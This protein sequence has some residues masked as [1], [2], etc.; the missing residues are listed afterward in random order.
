MKPQVDL[1]LVKDALK[2]LEIDHLSL[3][4]FDQCLP[5]F[6]DEDIGWGSPYSNGGLDFIEFAHSI[7]FNTIQFGPKGKISK[8]DISP[9]N[10]T[11][12]SNNPLTI[13]SSLL[14]R[15]FPQLFTPDEVT[16]L[17]ERSCSF[18]H[19]VNIPTAW[20]SMEYL[21]D[22]VYN[23]LFNNKNLS[24]LIYELDVFKSR[25]SDTV[26]NWFKRDSIFETLSFHYKTD[27]WKKWSELDQNLFYYQTQHHQSEIDSRIT[28]LTSEYNIIIQKYALSQFLLQL[29]HKYLRKYAAKTGLKIYGDMQIGFSNQDIWAW[30][31]L[32]LNGY[33]MG[34][35]PSRS[36]PQGQPWGYPVL[37]PSLFFTAN[38]QIGPA[39]ELI[40][41]RIDKMLS[42][43]DG[44]RIDHPHGLISPW[45]YN[46]D[47][48]DLFSAV[49]KGARLYSSPDL[50][51]HPMLAKFT[52]VDKNQLNKDPSCPRY[53]DNWVTA[54]NSDQ[55]DKY[56][57]II[58][59]ILTRAKNAGASES[60]IL[61]E[62]LSTWPLPLKEVMKSRGLGR[63]CVTQKTDPDNPADIYRRE[64]SS[65]RDWIMVG[66][67]DTKPIWRLAAEKHATPW[68][69]S[70]AEL[71]ANQF[72]H[73][74]QQKNILFNQIMNSP[75]RFC[76]AMFSELFLG[77]ARNVFIFFTDLLGIK[78]VYNKP[79]IIDDE[80]WTIR[81]P[82]DYHDRYKIQSKNGEAVNIPKCLAMAL[83][84]RFN[85][86]ED[87]IR[88]AERLCQ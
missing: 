57:T 81:I 32:F 63:F 55:T 82:A 24:E 21:L 29:Q 35:P 31:S 53:A 12:F 49:Q 59:L 71:L 9:Y 68:Y 83:T 61:C 46:L 34:A 20:N 30:R 1:S 70:R 77:P 33:L 54:L 84:A 37:D 2:M 51:D 15:Q 43:F 17:A 23:R 74:E 78:E 50:S 36:N 45:V 27:D 60:D 18:K 64:N 42:E 87:V 11:I 75:N 10:G 67:H 25:L 73:T 72:S 7:G 19:K 52:I 66:N 40:Q 88:L 86:R 28:E 85:Q 13:S 8:W 16:I 58:D 48:D 62:V 14:S 79:G 56:A 44:I 76:E 5:S 6:N 3:G 38:K 41:T 65:A 4:V 80:N 47:S 22:T 26:V 39:L 69:K